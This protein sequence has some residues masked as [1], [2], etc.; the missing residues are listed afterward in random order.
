M[1]KKNTI[2]MDVDINLGEGIPGGREGGRS[3]Q[4]PVEERESLNLLLFLKFG[5][6]SLSFTLSPYQ[7]NHI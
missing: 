2:R 7:I 1:R 5:D 3:T 6:L 4:R